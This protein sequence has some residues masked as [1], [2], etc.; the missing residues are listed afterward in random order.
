VHHV[1]QW[2]GHFLYNFPT[3]IRWDRLGVSI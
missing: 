1:V 2:V 3:H